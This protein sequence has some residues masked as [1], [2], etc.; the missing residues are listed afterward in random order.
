MLSQDKRLNAFASDMYRILCGIRKYWNDYNL[1][2]D[3]ED[4]IRV[5]LNAIDGKEE[6]DE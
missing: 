6:D 3:T 5:V 2:S 1:D 4:D